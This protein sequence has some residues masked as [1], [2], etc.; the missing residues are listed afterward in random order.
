MAEKSI[1][2]ISHYFGK[3][4][5]AILDLTGPLKVGD[6]IK[7]KHGDHVFEQLVESMQINHKKVEKAKKGDS[8]GI[9]LLESAKAK[10]KVFI[11]K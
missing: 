8:I 11:T 1:G 9:K 5:V 6:K 10:S 2:V 7:I 4:G 3:I